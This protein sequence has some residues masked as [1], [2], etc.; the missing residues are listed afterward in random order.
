M[1]KNFRDYHCGLIG[2][3][4]KKKARPPTPGLSTFIHQHVDDFS[5]KRRNATNTGPTDKKAPFI[6][7]VNSKSALYSNP[8]L[9]KPVE[10]KQS[11]PPGF[12]EGKKQLIIN[13]KKKSV[14]LVYFVS[15]PVLRESLKGR[16]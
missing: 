8:S 15:S 13:L 7:T 4:I 2:Y 12:K 1:L 6:P 14:S 9:L 3:Q 5:I 11:V 16:T 10:L